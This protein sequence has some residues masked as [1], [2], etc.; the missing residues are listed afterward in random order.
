MLV[1]PTKCSAGFLDDIPR[2][3]IYSGNIWWAFIPHSGTIKYRRNHTRTSVPGFRISGLL[4]K[5]E[6]RSPQS[7]RY[8]RRETSIHL[9]NKTFIMLKCRYQLYIYIYQ[10]SLTEA[11]QL[12]HFLSIMNALWCYTH[13]SRR[14]SPI[15]LRTPTSLPKTF[16][17]P[18]VEF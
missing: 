14:H 4:T 6:Y 15:P 9:A 3:A 12:L 13:E 2:G 16:L 11:Y 7:T 8:I 18:C 1:F 10:H 5:M 17:L